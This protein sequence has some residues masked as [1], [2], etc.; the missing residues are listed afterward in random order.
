MDPIKVLQWLEDEDDA[1]ASVQL[2]IALFLHQKQKKR[3]RGGSTNGRQEIN[4]NRLE[5]HERLHN[6]YFSENPTYPDNFFRR[7]FRMQRSLFLRIVE[8]VC[9]DDE[10]FLQ[11]R[12]AAKRLGFSSLQKV[13]AAFR[14][15]A[16]GYSADSLDEYLRISKAF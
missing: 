9:Q 15:L 2:N 3:K 8:D 5:G 13:V 7:R 14:M 1:V 12:D 11:K 10:Y 4:R 16:Y 6:D